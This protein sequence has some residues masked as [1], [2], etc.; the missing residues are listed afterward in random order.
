[1]TARALRLTTGTLT[2]GRGI[3]LRAEWRLDGSLA[4][5]AKREVD[6]RCDDRT[7]LSISGSV[8]GPSAAGIGAAAMRAR[9]S[10]RCELEV[11][12]LDADGATMDR[13]AIAR[14]V[15]LLDDDAASVHYTSAWRHRV[16]R[17]AYD[18][19]TTTSTRSGSRVRFT[20]TGDQVGLLATRGPGRGRIRVRIDGHTVATIDL[21]A[22]STSVR[23][24]VFVRSLGNG[25]H[26]IEVLH[27]KRAD[28]RTGRVDIDGFLLTRP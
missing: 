12:A 8:T 21:R 26:T 3:P 22:S 16:T 19:R 24:V 1:M 6:V 15:R 4:T 7:V 2:S 28:G 13:H 17:G 9:P 23:R 18:G 20:F 27:V 10:E 14:T 25:E 5:V 11:R